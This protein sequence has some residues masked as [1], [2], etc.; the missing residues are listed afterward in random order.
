LIAVY[1]VGAKWSDRLPPANIFDGPIFRIVPN[2]QLLL[3]GH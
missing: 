1:P 2:I 3:T